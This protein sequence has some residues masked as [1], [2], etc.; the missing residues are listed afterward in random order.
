[1]NP[2]EGGEMYLETEHYER[3]KRFNWQYNEISRFLLKCADKGFNEHFNWGRFEWMMVHTMLDEDKTDRITIFKSKSGEIVGIATFD[4]V[5]EQR[6]Y[7]LHS[8]NSIELLSEMLDSVTALDGNDAVIRV[9]SK[10][11]VLCGLLSDRQFS[12]LQS[13]ETI[14]QFD[15]ER[16]L[17]YSV[18]LGYSISPCDFE[19]DKWKYQTVIHKGFGG[20]GVPDKWDDNVFVPTPGY[21]SVLKVFATDGSEYCAHCGMWYT[22]GDTAYIEPVVTIPECR[23]L[24][25][26]KAVV[27]EAM[28]RAKA[29]GATRAIVV[30]DSEFYKKIGFEFSSE[31]NVWKK[32][33]E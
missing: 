31:V 17:S 22:S 11:S 15:L 8:A 20:E 26:A 3:N 30:S 16:D 23:K 32:A 18:P 29:L 13:S 9:N 21:N 19:F 2:S 1:M 10:D 12:M 5:Y 7:L 27:Y 14:M 25:L 33:E 24:G 6:W 28:R 4:T